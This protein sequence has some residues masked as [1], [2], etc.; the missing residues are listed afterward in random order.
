MNESALPQ[1][2]HVN[3]EMLRKYN[4]KLYRFFLNSFATSIIRSKHYPILD[5]A[6]VRHRTYFLQPTNKLSEPFQYYA[7][8]GP[9]FITNKGGKPGF[10][11]S[12]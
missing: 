3:E 4:I 1:T 5:D 12:I 2:K 11:M 9:P 8:K 10:H 7:S 6:S